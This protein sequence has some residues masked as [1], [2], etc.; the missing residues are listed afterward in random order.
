M[1]GLNVLCVYKLLF[2]L[3]IGSLVQRRTAQ[4]GLSI[5]LRENI[6]VHVSGQWAEQVP[7]D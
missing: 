1:P 2:D 4:N 7:S 6:H 3:I 5:F